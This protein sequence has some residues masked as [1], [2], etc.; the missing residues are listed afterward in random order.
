[1]DCRVS[2]NGFDHLGIGF[3]LVEQ[4]L[5]PTIIDVVLFGQ[6]VQSINS[7]VAALQTF[8]QLHAGSQVVIT[9][10]VPFNGRLSQ[11]S[12]KVHNVTALTCFVCPGLVGSGHHLW[13]Y[14]QPLGEWGKQRESLLR[15]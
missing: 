3:P 7:G 5:G 15:V 1:M 11:Q 12:L 13:L 10:P 6:F 2:V 9:K 8:L 14:Q 4:G